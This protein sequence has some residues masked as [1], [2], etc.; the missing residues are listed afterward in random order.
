VCVDE[1]D[2]A[3]SGVLVLDSDHLDRMRQPIRQP[4]R[5]VLV[6][7]K[8]PDSLARAWDAGVNSVVYDRDPL[9][10]AVLAIL[11]AR[12]RAPKKPR[13]KEGLR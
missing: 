2:Q 5:V 6:A 12:L 10:T 11:S 8:N 1:L 4:E 3:S 7:H 9:N 13:D